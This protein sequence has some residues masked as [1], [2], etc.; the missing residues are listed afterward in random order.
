MLQQKL[1]VAMFV[2]IATLHSEGQPVDTEAFLAQMRQHQQQIR[3]N[4]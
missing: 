1:A 3:A 4:V 2:A